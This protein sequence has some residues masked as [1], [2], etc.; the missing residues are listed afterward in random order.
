MTGVAV[1]A[2][3]D[4]VVHSPVVIVRL[5]LEMTIGA[6]EHFEIVGIGVAGGAHSCCP[7]MVGR[8]PGVIERRAR[9]YRCGVAGLTGGREA[10]RRVVGIGGALVYGRMT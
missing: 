8:E 10:C 2:V 7:S 4:V 5:G 9:P 6:R 1:Q 3:V